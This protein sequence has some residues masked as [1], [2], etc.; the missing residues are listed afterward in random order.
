VSFATIDD[1]RSQLGSRRSAESQTAYSEK[2]VHRV[3]EA[4]V[5]DRSEF[6]LEQCRGKRVL[7]LGASGVLQPKLRA[8][9]LSYLGIDRSEGDEVIAF[10]LDDVSQ[11]TL[12]LFDAEVIVCGE[13]L[14][15]LSNPG[16]LLKR[17]RSQWPTADLVITVPNAFS[18]IAARQMAHGIENVNRDHVCW[19]SFHTLKTLLGRAGYTDLWFGWYNGKP[20]TAEGLVVVAK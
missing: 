17:I 2:M 4:P 19:Y 18:Q 16:W 1:L 15:H 7:E 20:F 10:D 5:V 6:L 12:P 13:V 3:P 9:S 8:A 14:E 11:P